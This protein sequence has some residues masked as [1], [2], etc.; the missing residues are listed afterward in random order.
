MTMTASEMGSQSLPQRLG[1]RTLILTYGVVVY[2]L[3]FATFSYIPIFL[4][5]I[6]PGPT[7][8]HGWAAAATP[9]TAA[10][11]MSASC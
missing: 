4:A 11:S 10:S 1:A 7:V 9:A 6:G 5:D 3:F 2:L 8:D